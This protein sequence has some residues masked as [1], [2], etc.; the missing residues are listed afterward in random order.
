MD[1]LDLVRLRPLMA[2]TAGH[3]DLAIGLIDGPVATQHPAF[4][5]ARFRDLSGEGNCRSVASQACEHGTLVAGLLA[6]ARGTV[7]PAICPDCTLLIR[8]I[9]RES[10]G[11]DQAI[12]TPEDLAD[13][14]AA[15]VEGGARILNLSVGLMHPSPKGVAELNRALDYAARREVICVAAAGNQGNV[16][17]SAL[18]RHPWV[19]PVGACDA[20]GRPMPSSNLGSAIGRRGVVAPGAG[21]TSV[22][23]DGMPRAFGGTSAAAP[24][25]TGTL[26]LLWSLFPAAAASQ[27][28]RAIAQGAGAVR[29]T[30]VPPLLDAFAAYRLLLA[31]RQPRIAS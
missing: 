30:V 27:L 23:A 26:A 21:V 15:M 25:V 7:V 2:L 20:A 16:G 31:Q 3:A 8:P 17:G 10:G 19:L 14:I 11:G 1:V 12:A 13:A 18:T 28:L 5:G 22:G 6:A 9:F 4:A 24:F 29:R